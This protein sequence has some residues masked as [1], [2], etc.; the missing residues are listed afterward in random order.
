MIIKDFEH[1]QTAHCE[2][3][4]TSSLLS[5]HGLKEISEPL[6]FGIG[7]GLFYIQI[8]LLKVNGGP[9][10]SFRTMPGN[11]F[12][13]TVK[14]LG[15]DVVRKKFN[16]HKAAQRFLDQQIEKGNPVGAQ[17]GVYQLP[18]FPV[19]YR[20][21]FNAHNI[22][23]FGK[24]G[25]QYL[26]SDPVMETTTSLSAA[27]LEKVRFAKGPLAPK[28]QIYFP[29]NVREIDQD[30]LK[31]AIKRGIKRN[32]RDMLM[33]PGNVAGVRGIHY[34][35]KKVRKWRDKLGERKGGLYLGQIVRMQEEIGTG[36]GGFRFIYAAFLQEAAQIFGNEELARIAEDFSTAGDMWRDSAVNMAQVY[37]GRNT[38]QAQFNL[39]ADQMDAIAVLEKKAFEQLK[40]TQKHL[41]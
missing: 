39:C 33:I 25:D 27:E 21:H 1:I 7:A 17:V 26:V 5:Y 28:G 18:Y 23:I 35:A 6:A 8:P 14:S 40:K 15:I 11:I 41:G 29:E 19:E 16:D 20:F 37:R 22:I 24:E 2:N 32:V 38:S 30:T 13:Q 34:T 31:K 3:G 10:I 4:V 36:G 9:A 12:K